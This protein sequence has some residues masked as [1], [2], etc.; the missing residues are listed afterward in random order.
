[1]NGSSIHVTRWGAAGPRAVLVHGSAKGSEVGGDRH[2]ARQEKLAADGLQILV[3]DRPGHG[4]SPDAGRPDDAEADGVWVADMLEDG[5][6]LVGHSFGGC[7]ALAAAARKPEAVRSLTLIEPA[8]LAL[9]VNRPEVRSLLLKIVATTYLTFSDAARIKRFSTL[10]HIPDEIRG[11]ADAATL[12]RMGKAIK[13]LRLPPP[14]RLRQQLE[15]VKRAGI[16]FLVV[17]GGWSPAFEVAADATAALGAGRRLVIPSPHHF[18]HLVSDAFN[19]AFSA[20][21]RKA[22]A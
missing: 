20:L 16:P 12:K 4:R 10:L 11:G 2:F 5:A 8:V 13:A 18:P 21:V 9:A 1:L 22:E 15:S 7:V 19:T 14:G 6:H 3:P 17:T